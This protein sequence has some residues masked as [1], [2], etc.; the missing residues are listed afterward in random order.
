ME[1][2]VIT[3]FLAYLIN[4]MSDCVQATSDQCLAKGLIAAST[5]RKVLE[6]GGT[7]EDK[8][9]ILILG[10]QKSTKTD[11]NCFDILLE[12]L[13]EELPPASKQ[14]LLLEMRKEREDRANSSHKVALVP[15]AHSE[16]STNSL[17]V[18]LTIASLQCVQEQSSLLGRFE[19]SVGRLSYS[20]AQ[21]NVFEEELQCRVK[22]SDQLKNKLAI[23]ECQLEANSLAT[24]KEM[25]MT[26]R[27]ISACETEMDTLK[28]KIEELGGIIEEE[29]M[30]AKR[31]KYAIRIRTKK[32]VDQV[33]Q[34]SQQEIKRNREKFMEIL[35][36]KE[37]ADAKVR[38]LELKL[39]EKELK[40]KEMELKNAGM[41]PSY[42]APSKTAS[43]QKVE[44]QQSSIPSAELMK[45][46]SLKDLLR[47]LYSHVADKWD[48]IGN[49]LDIEP[50]LLGEIKA[51]YGTNAGPCLCE[52][53]KIWLK[54]TS[55]PPSWSAIIDTIEHLGESTLATKLRIKYLVT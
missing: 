22:E 38:E 45:S 8:A 33:V 3:K 40:I 26:K 27:R 24:E 53:L 46:P 14:K 21:K 43:A 29:N 5:Y 48:S 2:E 49:L 47:E 34:Q 30:Q 11:C 35:K 20:S 52:V 41:G 6:S 10:V 9:R 28:R 37:Q 4:A 7:S 13:D 18:P 32:L 55:P 31:G 42:L 12:I 16:R 39:W 36:R 44:V 25:S 1:A 50:K 15:A 19:N 17:E 54:R 23:L 51:D